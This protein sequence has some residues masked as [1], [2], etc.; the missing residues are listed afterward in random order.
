MCDEFSPT[1]KKDSLSVLN[2]LV[3]VC[4]WVNL[5]NEK[6]LAMVQFLKVAACALSFLVA[7]VAA[8]AATP[9]IVSI[10]HNYGAPG[11]VNTITGTGFGAT[12]GNSG[13]TFGPV[14]G[15][16]SS[17]S[18]T[19][20]VVVV[21]P[22]APPGAVSITVSTDGGTSNPIPFTIYPDP[23]ITS[24]S[25][26]TGSV[27]TLVTIIGSNLKDPEGLGVV[28]FTGGGSVP[29]LSNTAT[30]L[31][32]SVPA[33]AT[34]GPITVFSS[35]A[36]VDSQPFTVLPGALEFIAVTPCRVVDTRNTAGPMGGPLS[37]QSSREFDIPTSAC[38]IPTSALAYSLNVTVV[39]T[40]KLD[41][42]TLWPS[43]QGQPTASTLNSSDGRYKANA[44]IVPAGVNGGVS[45]FVSDAT[46]VILD[47]NGYFVPKGTASALAFYP[48]T[49]CRVVDTRYGSGP[50]AG[51]SLSGG[52]SRDFPVQTSCSLPSNAQAYSLNVTAL[53]HHTLNYLT[54]W[55]TGQSRP[56]VSTLNAPTGTITANAAI[57]P[58]NS[59]GSISIF[60]TDDADLV[61]DVNGFFATPSNSGLSLY[62]MVPCRVL[63]TRL[64]TGVFN[65]PLPVTVQAPPGC[66]PPTSAK[67]YVLNATVVPPGELDYLTLWPGGENQPT[68]STLNALD[69]ALTSNMAITPTST[70]TVNV[71]ASNPTNLV[72]DVTSYFAP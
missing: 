3:T 66:T 10:T 71:F 8:S 56:T 61:L 54:A 30:Q 41:Y 5:G 19:S 36:P 31:Q 37:A 14:V 49:P 48:M 57:V 32:V 40:A 25:P 21:P 53:P 70:G 43:G 69:G 62:A 65:G 26:T 64:G 58:A 15:L 39:P 45:V 50:L 17:W 28:S 20:I 7:T 24:I 72:V 68:A 27:G 1:F 34:S 11:A 51:P 42:L 63:D 38:N 6:G 46:N 9:N 33:G 52:N 60:V 16:I 44:A 23:V 47:I 4:C 55:A 22:T 67:A 13:V 18:D 2:S 12:Q 35:G 59:N 29:I